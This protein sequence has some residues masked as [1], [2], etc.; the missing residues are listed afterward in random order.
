MS[1]KVFVFEILIDQNFELD[2][3]LVHWYLFGLFYDLMGYG[4][5][6]SSVQKEAI[7]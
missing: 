4:L 7:L 1:I 3:G 6:E 2:K 5:N